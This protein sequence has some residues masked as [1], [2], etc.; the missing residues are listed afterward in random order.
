MICKHYS[1]IGQQLLQKV[2]VLTTEEECSG[3]NNLKCCFSLVLKGEE[4]KR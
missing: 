1:A 4:L 3:M 2:S